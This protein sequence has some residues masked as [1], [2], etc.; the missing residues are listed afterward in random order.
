MA[1]PRRRSL[2]SPLRLLAEQ[3]LPARRKVDI[4]DVE[5]LLEPRP[6][7]PTQFYDR[8]AGVRFPVR[9]EEYRAAFTPEFLNELRDNPMW[10]DDILGRTFLP[11]PSYTRHIPAG[12]PGGYP[13]GKYRQHAVDPESPNS[14]WSSVRV[15]SRPAYHEYRAGWPSQD[16][17]PDLDNA[18]YREML[19]MPENPSFGSTAHFESNSGVGPFA[20]VRY[21][22]PHGLDFSNPLNSELTSLTHRDT[23]RLHEIQSDFYSVPAL[24]PDTRQAQIDEAKRRLS[25]MQTREA[26]A[27]YI[28]NLD[29]KEMWPDN[30]VD[31]LVRRGYP[32]AALMPD[33]YFGDAAT[34]ASEYFKREERRK[35]ARKYIEDLNLRIRELNKANQIREP[36]PYERIWDRTA[37][38]AFLDDVFKYGEPQGGTRRIEWPT[39][40]M[41]RDL[42]Y[43]PDSPEIDNA[44]KMY[45]RIYNRDLPSNLRR[46][47]RNLGIDPKFIIDNSGVDDSTMYLTPEQ[48][49]RIHDVMERYGSAFPLYKEGGIVE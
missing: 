1:S 29:D 35:L 23:A 14:L 25:E 44:M 32:G 36:G 2:L 5:R 48:V 31:E 26:L 40:R 9:S 33:Q 17:V 47:M 6:D 4:N 37:T 12:A 11:D 21:N 27:R 19:L 10:K 16:L 7:R 15:R 39:P 22:L 38:N 20:H 49:Q 28:P 46:A 45:E 34:R 30:I 18:M 43:G 41:H 42:Y 24:D 3:A 13:I 8:D